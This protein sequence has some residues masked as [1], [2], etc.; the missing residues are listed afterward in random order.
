MLRFQFMLILVVS[1]WSC[2]SGTNN[3]TSN[4]P[5]SNSD[6]TATMYYG[7]DIITMEG[8][9]ANY[10][11]SVVVRDGKILFV[12]SKGDAMKAA[13]EGHQMVDLKGQ[14]MLPG[15]IDAHGHLWMA[16][17]QAV[18]ANLL[19]APDG[20]G[21]DIAA[22]IAITNDWKAKNQEVIAKTGWIVGF[23]YDEAQLKENRHPTAAE[24]DKVSK[25]TPVLFLHQSG[26]LAAV[27]SKG[28][29]VS[30]IS[31]T[32]KDPP[33]GLIQRIKGTK[34]PNGVLEETAVF[35]P[36]GTMLKKVDE[37]GNEALILAG[38]KSYARYGFTTAQEG[39]ATSVV[40][41]T[42]KRMSAAGTLIMDVYAYPDI[43]MGLEYMQAN[44]VQASYNNHFRVAGRE[45]Q[46]GWLAIRKNSLA[47]QAL[48]SASSGHA[49]E[50]SGI[51]CRTGH[52][53]H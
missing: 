33:G 43:Q 13:G 39:R 31:A 48:Q 3:Q 6:A 19:P 52:S 17:I 9:S 30:G 24:L 21:N 27:N 4:S 53:R 16:G 29:E 46:P 34:Q 32:T 51:S 40:V 15:F 10:A 8:D 45:A 41:D 36:A 18:A 11:E 42:Y 35:A 26:H 47:D 23:G 49:Q 38:Q 28:L 2:N 12:G 7:G 20:K 22:L 25:D 1:L 14:T 44:G 50:L 37:K 5:V